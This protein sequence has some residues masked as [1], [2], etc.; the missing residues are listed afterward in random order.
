MKTLVGTPDP[1]PRPVAYSVATGTSSTFLWGTSVAIGSQ[2][3]ST[4]SVTIGWA[5]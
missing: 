3:T 5:R 2:P 1:E 4:A